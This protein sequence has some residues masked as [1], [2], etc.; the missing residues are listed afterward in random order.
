MTSQVLDK[1]QTT[2]DIVHMGKFV[3]DLGMQVL[4]QLATCGVDAH[5]IFCFLAISERTPASLQCRK[6][7]SSVRNK[8]RHKSLWLHNIV[9][10]GCGT[11]FVADELLKTRAGENVLAMLTAIIP[12]MGTS[13]CIELLSTLFESLDI[14]PELSPGL[15]QLENLHA[16]IAPLT[17]QMDFKDQ[18][19]RYHAWLSN[20]HFGFERTL[21]HYHAIP[22][23]KTTAHLVRMF[24]TL[25]TQGPE[26]KLHFFGLS[27]AG[28]VLAY[29]WNILG[30]PTCAVSKA[31]VPIP[32]SADY[33]SAR[34]VVHVTEDLQARCE[35]VRLSKITEIFETTEELKLNSLEPARR[36][37]WMVSM[38]DADTV[39]NGEA[40]DYPGIDYLSSTL[41]E[42]LCDRIALAKVTLSLA[43]KMVSAISE[44]LRVEQPRVKIAGFSP[45]DEVEVPTDSQLQATLVRFGLPRV[46]PG[47]GECSWVSEVSNEQIQQRGQGLSASVLRE[48]SFKGTQTC[49]GEGR[50]PERCECCQLSNWMWLVAVMSA[51]LAFTN[52]HTSRPMLP[53]SHLS[54][55]MV[56]LMEGY[57]MN[58]LAESVIWNGNNLLHSVLACCTGE[59]E[60]NL[61]RRCGVPAPFLGECFDGVVVLSTSIVYQ[62][63]AHLS[64]CRF[65]IYDGHLR[66]DGQRR[67]E[68]VSSPRVIC[69]SIFHGTVPTIPIKP[70]ET[71]RP[72]CL[73]NDLS[74]SVEAEAVPDA[75]RLIFLLRNAGGVRTVEPDTIRSK[76]STIMVPSACEHGYTAPL[77]PH[78]RGREYAEWFLHYNIPSIARPPPPLQ[79]PPSVAASSSSSPITVPPP[80]ATKATAGATMRSSPK[81]PKPGPKML[82][83]L[84]IPVDKNPLAQWATIHDAQADMYILQSDCCLRCI[85]ERIKA[86][87]M[88]LRDMNGVGGGYHHHH[89][90]QQQ[91]QHQQQYRTRDLPTIAIIN[92]G[93]RKKGDVTC[94]SGLGSDG[95]FNQQHKTTAMTTTTSAPYSFSP[96]PTHASQSSSSSSSPLWGIIQRRN[97]LV[98]MPVQV[99][100]L[101]NRKETGKVV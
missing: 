50:K 28:W 5:T 68:L 6:Q 4:K 61:I 18:V 78:D 53:V 19:Y 81:K 64:S 79:T 44:A 77:L 1:V 27:C 67:R 30:L 57:T 9:E 43:R 97:G 66:L 59:S 58:T 37:G 17:R 3:S 32:I 15:S 80:I 94:P 7:L 92:G 85:M 12:V 11:N 87:M 13:S 76:L 20:R 34:V 42:D 26:H 54:L 70:D 72:H 95:V 33:K 21:S 36:S 45:L 93:G 31:G 35:V 99:S 74:Y 46:D 101:N 25:T 14:T 82:R 10:I 90:Q 88:S 73:V 2:W 41:G 63:L 8:Q 86:A 83:I 75:I 47:I 60:E 98:P 24:Y 16:A 62:D 100:F 89:H 23:A 69:D 48:L 40:D 91:Q 52:W 84:M 39:V 96:T 29:S 71:L 38:Q 56:E 51:R 49:Q 55:K 65:L 22:D